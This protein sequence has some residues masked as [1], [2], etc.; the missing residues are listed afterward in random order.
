M[1]LERRRQGKTCFNFTSLDED[2][3]KEIDRLTSS[4]IA[5]FKKAGFIS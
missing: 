1:E 3:L 2:A 4:S 5:A